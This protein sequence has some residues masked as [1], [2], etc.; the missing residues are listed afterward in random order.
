[1]Q[2]SFVFMRS[3][4]AGHVLL[5]ALTFLLSLGLR[6]L[7]WPDWDPSAARVDGEWLAASAD[8]YGWYAGATG[9]NQ[10]SGEPLARLLRLLHEATGWQTGNVGF[11]LPAFLAPMT[12]LPICLLILRWGLPEA[13]VLSGVMAGAAIPYLERTRLGS[14]DTDVYTLFFPV[15][16]IVFLIGWYESLPGRQEIGRERL[17]D[18]SFAIPPLIMGLFGKAYL[19]C[20]PGG[21][22]IIL[23]ILFCLALLLL[24]P[25]PKLPLHLLGIAMLMVLAISFGKWF[26]LTAALGIVVAGSLRPRFRHLKKWSAAVLAVLL[27]AL[28]ADIDVVGVVLSIGRDIFRY[29]HRTLADGQ[30]HL[31][32]TIR[33]VGEAVPT[34]PLDAMK[35]LAG[36]WALFTL[37]LTGYLYLVLQHPPALLFLPLLLLAIASTKLGVRF[38]MYGGVVMGLGLG[39]G[40]TMMLRDLRCRT[41]FRWLTQGLLLAFTLWTLAQSLAYFRPTMV[42]SKPYAETLREMR[43]RVDRNAQ[44]WSWWDFGY[45]VQYFAQRTTFADGERNSGEYLVPLSRIYAAE[46]SDYARNIIAYTASWQA[47]A[48]AQEGREGNFPNYDNPFSRLLHDLAPEDARS[49]I[50]SLAEVL[51]VVDVVSAPQ[52]L[53]VSWENLNIAGVISAFGTMDLV[54]GRFNRGKIFPLPAAPEINWE[55]GTLPFGQQDVE[56]A[57]ADLF[58][59]E[60]H[61]HSQWPERPSE[62]ALVQNA[63]SGSQYLMDTRIY[64]SLMIQ[65]LIS[66]PRQ[67]QPYFDLTLDRSPFARVYRVNVGPLERQ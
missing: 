38:S 65:L 36:N 6:L 26:S 33:T 41:V 44:F 16:F 15:C 42:V 54:D 40:L 52:Y 27:T 51:P 2:T 32:P 58:T 25:R 29:G 8:T 55:K 56:L 61:R 35:L 45:A 10:H 12:S 43:E 13:A 28:F 64:R 62:W 53:V 31:P 23:S 24:L 11:W 57:S 3:L 34:T 47:K 63:I 49:L 4:K 18:R 14:L 39:C 17:W 67:F 30:L 66:D 22:S 9:I 19:W 21:A 46:S 20:Y 59:P 37:G 48:N 5:L 7:D 50:D 60:G 1:L